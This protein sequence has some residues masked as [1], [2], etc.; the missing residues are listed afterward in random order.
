MLPCSGWSQSLCRTSGNLPSKRERGFQLVWIEVDVIPQSSRVMTDLIGRDASSTCRSSQE[1]R[2]TPS[3]SFTRTTPSKV[4]LQPAHYHCSQAPVQS[5]SLSHP[6][7][8]LC[9][10]LWE[11]WWPLRPKDCHFGDVD[12]KP[13][14]DFDERPAR[15]TCLPGGLF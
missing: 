8:I 15:S 2:D 10:V 13:N 9:D 7:Q 1:A 14:L 6:A 11:V 4:H 3:H 5:L 12:A